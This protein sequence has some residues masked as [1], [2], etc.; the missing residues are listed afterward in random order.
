MSLLRL[1]ETYVIECNS[2]ERL[3]IRFT[4]ANL[5]I[6]F[7]NYLK[8]YKRKM[9]LLTTFFPTR[10]DVKTFIISDC[11]DGRYH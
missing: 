2:F 8:I 9:R 11:L 4:T 7:E 6:M 5:L 10:S 3:I 1:I